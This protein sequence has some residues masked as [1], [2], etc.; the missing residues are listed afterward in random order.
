MLQYHNLL[1]TR[2]IRDGRYVIVPIRKLATDFHPLASTHKHQMRKDTN[3]FNFWVL[4]IIF[5]LSLL[6][7]FAGASCW[8][9]NEKSAVCTLIF[10]VGD[11]SPNRKS[12]SSSICFANST[13]SFRKYTTSASPLKFPSS[14]IYI[15]MR[16]RPLSISSAMTPHFENTSFSSSKEAS[17][18]IEY[19]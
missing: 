19:T 17:S 2:R 1:P 12:V 4:F 15:F 16:G 13:D 18:G 10:P 8:L 14:S 5:L 9:L 3:L 11:D 6:L 7:G